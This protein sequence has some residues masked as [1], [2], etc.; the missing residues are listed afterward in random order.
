MESLVLKHLADL[1]KTKGIFVVIA[2]VE[3]GHE[4]VK[5]AVK[6]VALD[7]TLAG[8]KVLLTLIN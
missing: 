1:V 2:L 7:E 3:Q 5:K 6:A 8:A 4:K